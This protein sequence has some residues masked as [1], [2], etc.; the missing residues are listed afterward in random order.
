MYWGDVYIYNDKKYEYNR[1]ESRK[2]VA[3]SRLT[4]SGHFRCINIDIKRYI[5]K[6]SMIFLPSVFAL[7]HCIFC[8]FCKIEHVSKGLSPW[9]VVI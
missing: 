3:L 6:L 5:I 1:C 4:G 9:D 7:F 2:G 8:L